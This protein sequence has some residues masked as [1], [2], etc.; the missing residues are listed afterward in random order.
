MDNNEFHLEVLLRE[1]KKG[2]L[3]RLRKNGG[4]YIRGDYDRESKRY[5]LTKWD[6]VSK[7]SYYRGDRK[8]FIGFTF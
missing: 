4:V 3:V 8:V 7:T 2:D 1:V 6:D 5:E